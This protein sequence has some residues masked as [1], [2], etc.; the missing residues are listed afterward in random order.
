MQQSLL[1]LQAASATWRRD[2]QAGS[3]LLPGPVHVSGLVDGSLLIGGAA[4]VQVDAVDGQQLQAII[5][6]PEW[7]WLGQHT[8]KC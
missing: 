5:T 3:L 6:R 4:A 8:S 2:A 7:S 1:T